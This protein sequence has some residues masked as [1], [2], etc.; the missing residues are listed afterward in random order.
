MIISEND[1]RLYRL[2]TL[3]NG[4]KAMLISSANDT[5]AEM[6]DD[7]EES[8]ESGDETDS[9][10]T[11]RS[12]VSAVCAKEKMAAAALAVRCGSFQ[13]PTNLGGLAHYLEHM[14]FM[15]SEKYPAENEYS[16]FIS[17]HGG[18]DNAFTDFEMT[19]YFFDVSQPAF[20]KALDIFANSFVKPLLREDSLEREVEAVESEFQLQQTSDTARL[21]QVL[22]EQAGV[23]HPMSHFCWG[24]LKS[25]REIP[26]EQ[27]INI[28]DA[29]VDFYNSYYSAEVM[30][31][32]V[33]SKHSLDEL[34]QFVRDSF[35]SVP[36]GKR[37]PIVYPTQQPFSNNPNFY[38]LF[39]VVPINRDVII[40]FRWVLPPQKSHYK[41]KCLDYLGYVVGH[42]GRNSI[43][44][45]LRNK[46]WALELSA[47]SDGDGFN[48][49]KMCSM[50]TITITLS[51]EGARNIAVVTKYV[52][53]YMHMLRKKGPQRWLW[54]ELKEIAEFDFRFQ[55]EEEAQDYVCGV[56]Q[57]MQDF[58]EEHYLCGSDLFMEYNATRIQELLNYMTP[59]TCNI[60][61][62]NCEFQK[63]PDQ[64]PLREAWMNVSYSIEDYPEE[65]TSLW[66]DDPEFQQALD[67]PEPNRYIPTD[68]SIKNDE[69]YCN[70][71]F[72]IVL[73][74]RA[75]SKLWFRKDEKFLVPKCFINVH[76]VTKMAYAN[77]KKAVC[78]DAMSD[79]LSQL[80]AQTNNYAE[81]ASLEY[82]LNG[83]NSG[84][85][86]TFS[87][88]NHKLPLL[89]ETVMNTLATFDCPEELF[90]TIKL[91]LR[92]HYYNNVLINKYYGDEIRSAIVHQ[93]HHIMAKRRETLKAITK[94]DIVQNA[95]TLCRSA[96][97]EAYIHGNT[98]SSEALQL[99]ENLERK[100]TATPADK[101]I[102]QL[103][104]I[105]EEEVYVRLLSINPEDKNSRI[106]NYY[107]Y[108]P[109]HFYEETLIQFLVYLMEE[110]CFKEL[111][112]EQQLGYDVRCS[113][114]IYQGVIG[115]SV[116]ISPA[117][118]KFTLTHVDEKI[119]EFVDDMVKMV[120]ELG[121]DEFSTVKNALIKIK[122][123]VDL[124]MED[125]QKRNWNQIVQFQYQFDRN[126]LETEFLKTLELERFRKW[127]LKVL[128]SKNRDRRKL[129]VQVVAYGKEALEEC[130]GGEEIWKK[131]EEKG[132]KMEQ[133][134]ADPEIPPIKML[135]PKK[136][137]SK[138]FIDDFET[139]F[140][141]LKYYP[142]VSRSPKEVID[143]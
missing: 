90:N 111:R 68:F 22:A 24:N 135:K 61:Y 60:M 51:E 40:T 120:E 31:L 11:D 71:E 142:P 45:H 18:S 115:F 137:G 57:A 124:S 1:K 28:R 87:G 27:G 73:V 33:Q 39:K 117:A 113:G 6:R 54:D 72:P 66:R 107:P 48:D 21:E 130:E 25:L 96:Y 129:S 13:E 14:L 75:A 118:T 121:F 26:K 29:L 37:V 140:A 46:Q 8:R 122:Q 110:R 19:V 88:F 41:E 105:I 112:T 53:Q 12:E 116:S 58:P 127:C 136:P 59:E 23:N 67:F 17:K 70:E 104:A 2:I 133:E 132:E 42:E 76:L 50:F 123:C 56:S 102:E 99:I 49:N 20:A 82:E 7:E 134:D 10:S 85:T 62:Y 93:K 65:W 52:H 100:L 114:N 125:E 4:L 98:T 92:K 128:P 47:G 143:F 36:R 97:V 35:S 91:S 64:F 109:A 63:H 5:D 9:E 83:L 81:M 30:T 89:F 126:Q 101:K 55:E 44:D 94:D 131:F 15:G 84:M 103:H 16:E 141:S 80:L 38:K 77:V 108:G 74:E 86:I 69:M 139:Y 138:K 119:D 78:L 43:L 3:K 32:C 34:E 106:V 95:R 79:I